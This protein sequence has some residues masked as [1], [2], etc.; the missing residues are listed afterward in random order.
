MIEIEGCMK[1]L[2]FFSNC[3]GVIAGTNCPKGGDSGH[4]GRTYL[5]IENLGGTDLSVRL[6]KA[7]LFNHVDSLEITLG[8]DSECEKLID[9]LKF[10]VRIIENQL[11]K[12][13]E[14]IKKLTV[15]VP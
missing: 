15:R 11:E 14:N 12:N 7:G 8:G 13:E 2:Y 4:G 1:E 6:D 9:A 3:L 5:R 10:A